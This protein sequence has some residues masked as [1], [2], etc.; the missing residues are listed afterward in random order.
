MS[1]DLPEVE[2]PLPDN[3][4][5]RLEELHRRKEERGLTNAEQAIVVS[6]LK[7]FNEAME[8]LVETMTDAISE[9]MADVTSAMKPLVESM[10][11]AAGT[12]G[13]I[14]QCEDCGAD[15]YFSEWHAEDDPDKDDPM[16]WCRDCTDREVPEDE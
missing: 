16:M 7:Q 4:L 14:G 9:M 15:I 1:D 5:D 13:I 6:D 10:N 12:V 8:P 2:A 11:E 3:L